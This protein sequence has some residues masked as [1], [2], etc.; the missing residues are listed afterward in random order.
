MPSTYL[1]LNVHAV[2]STK[3][4]SPLIEP[5][6]RSRAH[7]Y[8]GGTLRGLSVVP[9]Q[10]GGVSDHVHVLMRLK[11]T[12]SVAEVIR[13]AKK[14]STKWFREDLK[15]VEFA[16]QEGYAAFSV[17]PER[18][19]QVTR[20][21]ENQEEHHRKKSFEE[22]YRELLKFA[23]SSLRK[24]TCSGESTTLSGS[25]KWLAAVQG[26]STAWL[27]SLTT[28]W[29]RISRLCD[30]RVA[31]KVR[32]EFLNCAPPPTLSSFCRDTHSLHGQFLYRAKQGGGFS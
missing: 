8:L 6:I 19:G 30:Q 25:L 12:Q 21:I 22:E 10:V 14:S 24:G 7:E 16:W 20:Y 28:P 3:N 23:G 27:R 15:V 31:P 5:E 18:I 26:S 1:N 13:E 11:A 17:S 4:R 32:L 2:F 29:S 9:L